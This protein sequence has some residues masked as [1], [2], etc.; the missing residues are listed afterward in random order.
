MV[1]FWDPYGEPPEPPDHFDF[2]ED[3]EIEDDGLPPVENLQT[4]CGHGVPEQSPAMIEGVLRKGHKMLLAGPSKAGKSFA[5]IELA[6]CIASGTPWMNRFECRRGKVLYVNLEVDPASAK[7]RFHDVSKALELPEEAVQA[8]LPNI[9]LWNLR[10]YC[11]NW[12]HFVDICC[13]RA[14]REQYDVIIIDPFYKL[15]AGR[16]NNVFDMVQFCNGL[17]RISA[18]NGAAVIYCHHHSKGD[19]GWKNSMDRA[20]GSGVFARDVDA[21]LDIIELELPPERQRAGVRRGAS[22]AHC[23]SFPALSRWTCG[24]TTPSTLWNDSTRR[25]TLRRTPSS[26]PTSA[27]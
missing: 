11:I 14:R 22:R 10:G 2:M 1:D 3:C 27:Q 15:N 13:S 20:S 16:E 17:D 24:L 6:V 21:L 5:L 8:M 9:D 25:T 7:H 23:G 26:L 12:P 19:Q 4:A 18:V